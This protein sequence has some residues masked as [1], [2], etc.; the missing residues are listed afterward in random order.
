[1]ADDELDI[2][3]VLRLALVHDRSRHQD[4]KYPETTREQ[5]RMA[6]PLVTIERLSVAI[7]PVCK[8]KKKKNVAHA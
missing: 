6:V 1:M 8:N 5:Y 2:C 7:P 3:L 4:L